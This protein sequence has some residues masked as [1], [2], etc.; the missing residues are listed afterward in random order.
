MPGSWG[1]FKAEKY[2]LDIF[3]KRN[4]KL[5]WYPTNGAIVI[6]VLETAAEFL[7]NTLPM[8][9]KN[10]ILISLS[11]KSLQLIL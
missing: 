9:K 5:S 2:D 7:I 6:S 1:I 8:E 4:K 3:L 11:K 10:L